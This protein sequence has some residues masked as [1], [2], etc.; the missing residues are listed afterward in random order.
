MRS[1]HFHGL[2]D[3]ISNV[4]SINVRREE[5]DVMV[6]DGG[7]R[8]GTANVTSDTGPKDAIPTHQNLHRAWREV[9]EQV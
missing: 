3:A 9:L 5:D 2:D 1:D 6:R 4:M 8:A 7:R